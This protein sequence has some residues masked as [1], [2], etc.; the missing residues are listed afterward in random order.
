M[1]NK[2]HPGGRPPAKILTD[3][4]TELEKVNNKSHRK[5]WKCNYCTP[6]SGN[7]QRIEGQ[8]NRCLL[9]LTNP[10]DCPDAPP[11]VRNEARK[12][13]M[14][15]GAAIGQMEAPLFRDCSAPDGTPETNGN[16]PPD[17]VGTAVVATK[18]R[19]SGSGTLDNFVDCSLNTT[20]QETAN[21][22]LFR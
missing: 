7:G 17:T 12:A 19:K 2:K 16:S 20:Q 18:K 6:T 21:L 11:F 3:N 5:I 1:S 8:D 10:K 13:L 4:F 14:Q 9:H 22:K 15:K